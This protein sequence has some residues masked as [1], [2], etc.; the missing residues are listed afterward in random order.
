M[1]ASA[2]EPIRLT[3]FS[4]GGGCACKLDPGTLQRVLGSLGAS[5]GL[6]P[7][8]GSGH[9][10]A[11][12]LV[13]LE[14]GDDAAVWQLSDE[15]ALIATCDFITPIVDDALTWGRIAATNAV[16]DIYAMGGAP[17]LALNIVCWNPELPES[18]LG[19]VLAGG[20]EIA[21]RAGFLIA[22]GHSIVDPEPKYGLAVIGTV[23]PSRVITNAGLRPGDRLV[24]TKPLG[25]GI[26]TTAL[27]SGLAPSHSVQAAIDSMTTLNDEGA[28]IARRH[29]ASAMTDVTGFGL[30]GHLHKMV[31]A[32]GT[33]AEVDATAVPILPGAAELAGQGVASGGG[34]RN[35]E[36]VRP[37]LDSPGVSDETL[38]LLSDP[39]TSGGLLMGIGDNDVT[40]ALESLRSA[41][42]DAAAVGSVSPGSGH[43]HVT[44]GR[45][46]G[47]FDPADVAL[48]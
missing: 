24:L 33:D 17:L 27:R 26:I 8:G 32:S 45:P 5:S 21:K 34:R 18:V 31:A 20:G 10:P 46:T 39:Q 44:H 4:S 29:G 22:G 48:P 16:S 1:S 40:A 25:A 28:R 12:L 23:S 15:I 11:D 13:G 43:I 41:G 3:A 9:R 14:T 19:Q 35:L 37:F 2:A 30:L 7:H 38:T 6:G 47:G 36:W 42:L